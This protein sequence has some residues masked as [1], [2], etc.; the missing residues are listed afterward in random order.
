MKKPHKTDFWAKTAEPRYIFCKTWTVGSPKTEN[1]SK[2][3][4]KPENRA[5]F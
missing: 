4:P 3:M 2:F 1:R 5:Y